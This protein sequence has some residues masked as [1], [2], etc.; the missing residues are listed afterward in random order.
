LTIQGEGQAFRQA[1]PNTGRAALRDALDPL[2][3]TRA[4]PPI[5]VVPAQFRLWNTDA[6]WRAVSY[7]ATET[8]LFAANQP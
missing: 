4:S 6:K 2:A 8:F 7:T 1:R 5:S 3:D